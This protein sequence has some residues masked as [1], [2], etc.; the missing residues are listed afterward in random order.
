MKI[1]YL[2]QHSYETGDNLQYEETKLIGIY[3]S[4]KIAEAKIAEYLKLPGF[5]DFSKDTFY[6]DAYEI[7]KDYWT[8]GFISW[9][10]A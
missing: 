6:I 10:E 2:L 5:C 9:E 3:S 1:V 4:Q 7:D 8:E